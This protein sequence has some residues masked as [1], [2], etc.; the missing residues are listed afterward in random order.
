MGEGT[1]NFGDVITTVRKY[2]DIGC[3][4]IIGKRNTTKEELSVTGV[5][6]K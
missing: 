2:N 6:S 1:V 5:N 3:N 4:V